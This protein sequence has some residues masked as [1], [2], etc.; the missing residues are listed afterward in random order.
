MN[1][2]AKSAIKLILSLALA[3]ILV[4][5]SFKNIDWPQFWANLHCTRWSFVLLF[6]IC[7]ILAIFIRALRWH[8]M[9]KPLDP[10][11]KLPTIWDANN[12]GNLTNT[13]IPGSGEL[14]RCAVASKGGAQYNAV[15][16]TEIMERAW[17][18]LAIAILVILSL[19]LGSESISDFFSQHI[20]GPLTNNPHNVLWGTLVVLLVVVI[21]IL[22]SRLKNRYKL[23][24]KIYEF[25]HG[26]VAGFS[27]FRNMQGKGL[28]LLYTALLW[29]MYI[30]MYLFVLKAVPALSGLDIT[31]AILLAAIGN[32]ASVIPVPGGVGAY[33]YLIAMSL[34]SIYGINWEL[35]I[36]FATLQHELHAFLLIIL[37]VISYAH[38]SIRSGNN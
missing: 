25:F 30:L 15:L 37:G 29:G 1:K 12:I 21:V 10:D 27:S 14:I 2:K 23:F 34:S 18:G 7:A 4:W 6:C 8:Q 9:I 33:H 16:G 13:I 28:F 31:D 22:S 38:S 32:I 26:L 3:V 20:W 11:I 17:D 35:G 36:L 5:F 19:V 24:S